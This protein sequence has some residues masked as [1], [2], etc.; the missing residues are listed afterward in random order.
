ML[1]IS[2]MKKNPC[3]RVLWTNG[4]S[5]Y[6]IKLLQFVYA[7]HTY[8]TRL[9]TSH[10]DLSSAIDARDGTGIVPHD[11]DEALP[12]FFPGT[13]YE[14]LEELLARIEPRIDKYD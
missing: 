14:S 5:K 6:I 12:R 11:V 2:S 4:R 13:S 10:F 8:E 9:L 7:I 3:L 1:N